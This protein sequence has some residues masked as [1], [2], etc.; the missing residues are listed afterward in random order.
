M[1]CLL[2]PSK[3]QGEILISISSASVVSFM[4]KHH[5]GCQ[6][7][8]GNLQLLHCIGQFICKNDCS[9]VL[10]CWS[11]NMFRKRAEFVSDRNSRLLQIS[12]LNLLLTGRGRFW[13]SRMCAIPS[14]TW[15]WKPQTEINL[16]AKKYY[17]K[18]SLRRN[19]RGMFKDLRLVCW[20]LYWN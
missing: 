9:E 19:I 15:Q 16:E 2:F 18:I 8:C 3:G 11:M 14:S 12:R 7:L 4:S 17:K 20:E 13:P 10:I 6:E 5:S 1:A